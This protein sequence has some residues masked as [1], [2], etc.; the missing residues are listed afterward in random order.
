M[1]WNWHE[2][3]Q[4]VCRFYE[5]LKVFKRQE[6][7]RDNSNLMTTTLVS[8]RIDSLTC[9]TS[10][11]KAIAYFPDATTTTNVKINLGVLLPIW[12]S[13]LKNRRNLTTLQLVFPRNDVC[14]TSAEIPYGWRHYP[15][16]GSAF[17]WSW[18]EKNLF[19][20]IS[21]RTTQIWVMNVISLREFLQSLLGGVISS[22]RREIS[23]VF[24]FFRLLRK[25]TFRS[26]KKIP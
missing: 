18:R 9:I 1:I 23:A 4:F 20:P 22:W 10:H 15:D 13:S 17:D 24:F 2:I 25:E 26:Q 3:I 7:R 8:V 5:Q 16:L 11:C 6:N 12:R 14:V 19:H 21:R